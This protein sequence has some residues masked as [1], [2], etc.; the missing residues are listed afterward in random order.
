VYIESN[1]YQAAMAQLLGVISDV[2]VKPVITLKDKTSRAW[3]LSAKF[4][5]GDVY[6]PK[7]GAQDF[8]DRLIEFP[9]AESDDEFDAFEIAVSNAFKKQKKERRDFGVI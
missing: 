2:P 5:N 9:D 4:E 8:I 1:Q 6:F 7:F 3:T